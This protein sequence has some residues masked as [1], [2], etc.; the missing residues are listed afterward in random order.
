MNAK[1]GGP[2]LDRPNRADGTSAQLSQLM[3]R[4]G[5]PWRPFEEEGVLVAS[6]KTPRDAKAVFAACERTLVRSQLGRVQ[7]PG[8]P[9]C[10]HDPPGPRA[11]SRLRAGRRAKNFR[12]AVS[13][14]N[15][16]DIRAIAR[17]AVAV[18]GKILGYDGRQELR[19]TLHLGSSTRRARRTGRRCWSA[20][21]TTVF[22]VLLPHHDGF[23]KAANKVDRSR[24]GPKRTPD[25]CG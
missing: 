10:R 21:P 17:E 19:F 16:R 6:G 7:H 14:G 25:S 15:S 5:A 24:T 8:R 1:S 22:V 23:S 12:K 11:G 9:V 3:L 4:E 18:L 20:A 2:G 13:A